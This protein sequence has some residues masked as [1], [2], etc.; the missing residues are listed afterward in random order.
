MVWDTIVIGSGVGG[1]TAAAALARC[2]QR[3]LVLE[4]HFQLGG[5][6][7]TF[8]RQGFRFATGL[9]YIGGVGPRPGAGGSFGRLLQWL[10]DGSLQFAPL[11]PHFDT[12]R[13]RD[14]SS[15]NGEFVTR[16]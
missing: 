15:P 14:P 4:Q 3:V 7:Q 13:L 8:E 9:H 5:M 6:T 2:G 11:P 1:L 12:V 16:C 10:G